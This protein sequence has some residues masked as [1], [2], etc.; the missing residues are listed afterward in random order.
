MGLLG[1]GSIQ[2]R[3]LNW[4]VPVKRIIEYRYYVV[5]TEAEIKLVSWS[6]PDFRVQICNLFN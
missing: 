2:L 3:V 5:N 6:Y 1:G 4:K